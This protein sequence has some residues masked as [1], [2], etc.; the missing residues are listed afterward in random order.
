MSEAGT[1]RARN[2]LYMGKHDSQLISQIK[3]PLHAHWGRWMDKKGTW[4]GEGR[5]ADRI[6]SHVKYGPKSSTNQSSIVE[7]NAGG[8]DLSNFALRHYDRLPSIRLCLF[9]G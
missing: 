2:I 6:G 5:D 4:M 7:R 1:P 3:L 9:R 8:Q